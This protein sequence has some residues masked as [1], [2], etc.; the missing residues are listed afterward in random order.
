VRL[1]L[2]WTLALVFGLLAQT[3]LLPGLVPP[4]W[5]PDVTRALVLWVAL[6]GT[7]KGGPVLAFAAGLGLDLCS[8]APLGF[9]PALRL[10]VYALARPFR[11]VFFDNH[12]L[13]LMP[14][15][16]LGAAAD[17]AA[18]GLLSRLVFPGP[19]PG[20]VLLHVAWRQAVLDG[21]WV[22]AVFLGLELLAGRAARRAVR[23]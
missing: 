18:A 17:A 3:S 23:V 10:V 6:T 7:P 12:P 8:G 9:G 19:I 15:A 16:A 14:F 1:L 5:R 2:L 21:F 4:A 20:E 22:P 11:G 13:L